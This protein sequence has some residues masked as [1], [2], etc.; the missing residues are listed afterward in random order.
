MTWELTPGWDSGC[1]SREA[2]GKSGRLRSRD[3]REERM[4]T[5]EGACW[6][7]RST[8]AALGGRRSAE[9]GRGRHG[10][11]LASHLRRRVWLE[12]ELLL[13]YFYYNSFLPS[14]LTLRTLSEKHR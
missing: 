5:E 6:T 10:K 7:G 1:S 11:G 9:G 4:E 3:Q 13:E 8:G 12:T 14:P 2:E